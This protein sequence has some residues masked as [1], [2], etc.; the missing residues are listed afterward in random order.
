MENLKENVIVGSLATIAVAVA[1]GVFTL[2]GGSAPAPVVTQD[3]DSMIGGRVHNTQETFDA[4]IAV[5]GTEVISA[6]RGISATTLAGTASLTVGNGTPLDK[7]VRTTVTV[8]PDSLATGAGTSTNVTLTGAVVGDTCMAT[9]VSGDLAGTTSTVGFLTCKVLATNIATVY[10][11]NA[12]TTA[13][14]AGSNV[15]EVKTFS[16]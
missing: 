3:T 12:S 14:D 9:T 6:T 5:N 7:I 10:F 8:N 2:F 16:F 11:K 1:I 15:V 13:Y 4:G